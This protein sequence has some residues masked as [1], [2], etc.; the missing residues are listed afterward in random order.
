MTA[1][2]ANLGGMAGQTV[3]VVIYA[4]EVLPNDILASAYD[5]FF[6]AQIKVVLQV[7]QAA[8]QAYA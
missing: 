6:V 5:Q 4:T 2:A 8:H 3:F 1:K 7:Q